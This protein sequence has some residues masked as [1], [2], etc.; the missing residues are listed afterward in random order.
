MVSSPQGQPLAIATIKL[1]DLSGVTNSS[2]M[3]TFPSMNVTAS[4]VCI[5]GVTSQESPDYLSTP[6]LCLGTSYYHLVSI[7]VTAYNVTSP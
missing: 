5:R 7:L 1:D 6:A 4:S 3:A 2:G